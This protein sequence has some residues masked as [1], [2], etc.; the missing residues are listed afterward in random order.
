MN[1]INKIKFNIDNLSFEKK[2][3]KLSLFGYKC[4]VFRENYIIELEG[5]ILHTIPYYKSNKEWIEDEIKKL[6]EYNIEGL[7][8]GFK[9][10]DFSLSHE[11]VYRRNDNSEII[12]SNE[13]YINI[14]LN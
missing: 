4:Y 7:F 11:E 3:E 1:N 10:N 6:L 14:S 8:L 2:V 12:E 9:F 5:Q 13:C